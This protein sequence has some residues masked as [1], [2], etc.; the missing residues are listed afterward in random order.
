MPLV[1]GIGDIAPFI[2]HLKAQFLSKWPINFLSAVS[3][4]FD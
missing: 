4:I 3:L 2:I 1:E